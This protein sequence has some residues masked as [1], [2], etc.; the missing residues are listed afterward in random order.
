MPITFQCLQKKRVPMAAEV[1]SQTDPR[2]YD[3]ADYKTA[4][5]KLAVNL[6]RLKEQEEIN[7]EA[8]GNI[9]MLKEKLS[10]MIN[11]NDELMELAG[12]IINQHKN[13]IE[14]KDQAISKLMAMYDALLHDSK[15]KDEIISKLESKINEIEKLAS[16]VTS[17]DES[18]KVVKQKKK[19]SLA[20]KPTRWK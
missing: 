19:P 11:Q 20:I 6:N 17:I 8:N 16:Q 5:Y 1:S 12:S 9:A 3:T 18:I 10:D 15:I 4:L 2:G 14:A 7:E 13:D